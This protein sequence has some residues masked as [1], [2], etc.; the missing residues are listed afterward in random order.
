LGAT[1]PNIGHLDAAAGI[2]GLLKTVLCLR[3]R[4]L[5]PVLHFEQPNPGLELAG[6]PFSINAR[7][8]DWTPPEGLPRIA[9]VSSFGIGGTNAHVVVEEPPAVPTAK[10]EET[11][12]VLP[13]SARSGE[14]L[15]EAARRL[16]EALAGRADLPLADVAHTLQRG[17]TTFEQRVSLVCRD[18]AG[19][20]VGLERLARELERGERS[21]GV[22]RGR[23]VAFLFPGQGSQHPGMGRALYS[24]QAVFR[25]EVDRCAELLRPHLGLDVREL[26]LLEEG[27]ASGERIH[28]TALA[29]PCLFVLEYALARLWMSLGL[30]PKAMIG[31]SLGEYVAACLAGVF[32][33]EDALGLICARGRLM[34][35]S[36][37]GAM[38]AIGLAADALR[39]LLDERLSIAAYNAPALTVVAGPAEAISG[40]ERR[41][42]AEGVGCRRLRTSH[43][44]HSPLMEPALAPFAEQVRRVRLAAPAIPFISHVT[45]TWITAAQAMEP[46]YWVQHLRQPVRF[47]AGAACLLEG[48]GPERLLLEVGPGQ[49]LGGLIRQCPG[50]S[51]SHAV[52]SS[53]PRPGAPVDDAEFFLS[54]VGEA[55]SR[56]AA[57]DW[58]GLT[59]GERGRRVPLPTYPF[60]R[61][62]YWT[63]EAMPRPLPAPAPAR[64][65]LSEDEPLQEAVA[66][67]WRQ[68]LGLSG[69]GLHDDFF[70]LGGHSL[71]AVQLGARIRETFQVDFP[72]QRILEHPTVARL[73]SFLQGIARAGS[74]EGLAPH[75]AAAPSAGSSLLVEL[76]RGD[77][78]RRPLFLLHPV[79]GTVFTY[80]SLVRLLDPGLPIYGV[81]ARGLEPGEVPAGSIEAMA[82]LYLEAVRTRQPSGPYRL[83]G[84]SFGGVVAYEL[85][86]QLLARREQVESLVLL[87]S[88]GPGQM[89]VGLGSNDEIQEY[90]QRMAPELFRQLFLPPAA[91]EG[92]LDALLPRS[93]VFLQVF[94]E[95]ASAMFAYAP[96]SYPGRLVFFHA[97]ERDSINPRHPELAWIPLADGGVEVH[98]VPGNHVTMLAE[99]HVRSLAKKVRA[100]LEEQEPVPRQ[101][102]SVGPF[103][104]EPRDQAG[105]AEAFRPPS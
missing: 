35:A 36:P 72:Q 25:A 22:A 80:R 95:N 31:H 62:R 11:W 1:K 55:W 23:E 16:G 4:Q 90:F 99:P 70:E 9:G 14:A 100:I 8:S 76:N 94:R 48:E 78:R 38:L 71:L 89:P 65:P 104:P 6:T 61:R 87:D 58:S 57:V 92:S 54:Q 52:L 83:A 44:Y 29:Q 64:A 81:R 74:T 56:G 102:P 97:Q 93:E 41:L 91:P 105:H 5:P 68:L 96:R 18:V 67:I 50:F 2:A 21:P 15:A 47:A 88:P 26:L 27:D 86:Q 51:E 17:R 59:P 13:L 12:R 20:V 43:A 10:A 37:G 75:G 39:P 7:L 77:P 101:P 30:S 28:Q 40:L 33:L 45:G 19:A 69:V 82:T 32:S 42:E 85:A 73:A 79:G 3:H 63:D 66:A 49:T 53:L 34:Q 103:C 24:A 84:H 60:E 98:V 46:D